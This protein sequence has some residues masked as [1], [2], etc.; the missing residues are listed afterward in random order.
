MDLTNMSKMISE[1]SGPGDAS[2]WNCVP[3]NG[4]EM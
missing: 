1:S 2:G 3:K 4:F